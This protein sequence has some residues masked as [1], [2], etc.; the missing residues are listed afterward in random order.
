MQ[1]KI[2][3]SQRTG[4]VISSNAIFCIDARAQFTHEEQRN[5]A[6]YKLGSQVIYNSQTSRRLLDKAGA[7]QDGSVK[8]S[9][10]S[11]ATMALVAMNLNIS[12]NSL[13]RGQHIECKSLDELLAA[14]TALMEACE[15]L[16]SYL[17]TAASFDGRE[18]L[19]D[20]ATGRPE[21]VAIAVTPDPMLVLE[22]KQLAA[23]LAVV[24]DDRI[25][26]ADDDVLDLDRG[27][28]EAPPEYRQ[29]DA[30]YVTIPA[31]IDEIKAT[32]AAFPAPV[33]ILGGLVVLFVLSRLW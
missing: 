19:I 13:A 21:L 33:L 18:I 27:Y 11:L 31:I 30:G 6:R 28:Q 8:G 32:F 16:K 5:I 17:D 1:L 10:K 12:I 9:L 3:R 20:F 14:E 23:P 24:P 29:A 7:Q 26:H 4:G 15:N 2:R 22:P 25:V